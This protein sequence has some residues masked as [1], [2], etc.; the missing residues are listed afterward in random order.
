L[1]HA[2]GLQVKR[3][4]TREKWSKFNV[5]RKLFGSK[6]YHY[7]RYITNLLAELVMKKDV[8]VEY[9]CGDGI[10]LEHLAKLFPE[11]TF[12]G[13]EWNSRLAEYA[14][15]KRTKKLE[16]VTIYQRDATQVSVDCD[17]F[18]ALGVVEHFSNATDVLKSWVEH[19]KPNGF[20]LIC[21]PNLLNSTFMM[22]KHKLPLEKLL[23]KN[24]VVVSRYGY[25]QVWSHNLFLKKVMDAGLEILLFRV[26]E[27]QPER[28]LLVL[29]FKRSDS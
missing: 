8:V 9:G 22:R 4:S 14:K 10:W 7:D 16:N 27:E 26:V 19:L 3:Q 23:G 11:K 18:F 1:L 29:G 15:T 6:L 25:S 28:G 13:I 12:V 24:E 5:G 2:T 21:V 17:F 20:A